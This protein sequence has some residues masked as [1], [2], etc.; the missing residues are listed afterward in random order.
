[1]RYAL[2][3]GFDRRLLATNVEGVVCLVVSRRD[4]VIDSRLTEDLSAREVARS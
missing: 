3:A 4:R 1:M 2:L